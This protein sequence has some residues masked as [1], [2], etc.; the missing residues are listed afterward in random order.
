MTRLELYAF[1]RVLSRSVL[2]AHS[3]KNENEKNVNHV[4]RS[5]SL[6]TNSTS[7]I[8]SLQAQP[9]Y[10]VCARCVKNKG[11]NPFDRFNPHEY[12]KYEFHVWMFSQRERIHANLELWHIFTWFTLW[13]TFTMKN[14]YFGWVDRYIWKYDISFAWVRA[15]RKGIDDSAVLCWEDCEGEVWFSGDV[16]VLRIIDWL[17]GEMR[18]KPSLSHKHSFNQRESVISFAGIFIGLGILKSAVL[19][20]TTSD[21]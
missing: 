10:W 4:F 15:F 8:W 20:I 19:G 12:A 2:T 17:S 1:H 9:L 3:E 14:W 21:S 7:V 13:Q 5:L 6:P 18:Y 16:C 11:K